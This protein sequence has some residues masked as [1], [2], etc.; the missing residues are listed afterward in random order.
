M[1]DPATASRLLAILRDLADAGD[2][3]VIVEH[4]V[5]EALELRPDRVLYLEAGETRYLGPVGGF[6]EVAD[7]R[8]VKLPFEV[9]LAHARADRL[10]E[11]L[12]PPDRRAPDASNT[13]SPESFRSSWPRS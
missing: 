11:P 13:A 12:D 9:V 6:L 1:A 7:P 5:E 10:R 8:D 4:R 2:A 3:V